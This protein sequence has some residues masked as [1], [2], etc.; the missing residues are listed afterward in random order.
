MLT[1]RPLLRDAANHFQH[2][3]ASTAQSLLPAIQ[4]WSRPG[5][6]DTSFYIE[7]ESKLENH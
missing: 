5:V 3:P 1:V 4:R 7:H 2:V 6:Y